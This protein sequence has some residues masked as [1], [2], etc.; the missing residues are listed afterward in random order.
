MVLASAWAHAPRVGAGPP[1]ART[2]CVAEVSRSGRATSVGDR[3]QDA[4]ITPGPAARHTTMQC[5]H[6]GAEIAGKALVCYRCG[7][8]TAEAK[9][10][11]ATT[12]RRRSRSGLVASLLALVL[13]LVLALFMGRMPGGETPR[14]VTWA[15][16]TVALLIVGLRAYA[17]RR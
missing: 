2:V 4:V 7:T 1:R 3:A 17:R 13:L 12:S 14:H 6:C 10:A 11:P 9:Y 8:A 5:R 15:A 16:V